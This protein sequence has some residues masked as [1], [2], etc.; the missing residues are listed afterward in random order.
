MRFCST[1]EERGPWV[2]KNAMQA[3]T[4]VPAMAD[5][6]ARIGNVAQGPSAAGRIKVVDPSSGMLPSQ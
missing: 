3:L 6:T 2:I 1:G 4:E 5:S